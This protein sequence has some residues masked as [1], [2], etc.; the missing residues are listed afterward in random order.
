MTPF[1]FYLYSTGQELSSEE[2][3]LIVTARGDLHRTRKLEVSSNC[4]RA[5]DDWKCQLRYSSTY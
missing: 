3:G 5:D 1:T 2:V 4:E